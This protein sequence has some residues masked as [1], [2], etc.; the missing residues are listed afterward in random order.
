[1]KIGILVGSL[2]GGGAERVALNL[3]NAFSENQCEVDLILVRARGALVREL[4]K[5]V[6]VVDLGAS[7]ARYAILPFRRYLRSQAPDV[8]LAIAL[9]P[10]LV[11]SLAVLGFARRPLLLLTVHAALGPQLNASPRLWRML[12]KS[13]SR[14]L[15]KKADYVVAV[16]SGIAADLVRNSWV[17]AGHIRIIYNPVVREEDWNLSRDRA[18]I[19]TQGG[20]FVPTILSIGR[21]APEKN[22]ALLIKAFAQLLVRRDARLVILGE[23]NCRADLERCVAR[24]GLSEKVTLAGYQPN[25]HPYLRAADLFVLSSDFEGF[26][27]ALVEAMAAG[28]PVVSTDCPHGPREILEDGAWGRLVPVGNVEALAIAMADALDNPGA[29][30]TMRAQ[31][32]SV[33]RIAAKYLQLIQEGLNDEPR[34]KR[35]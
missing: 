10:N 26:G 2:E 34:G 5:K 15:Y 27:N 31:E 28:I 16:S 8:V 11:A 29:A 22:H 13:I 3:A 33:D 30:A 14:L 23:G 7:R 9:E 21:L 19:E 35:S 1:V 24:A 20:D 4:R 12:I 6:R 18:A 32:F 25:P 17:G